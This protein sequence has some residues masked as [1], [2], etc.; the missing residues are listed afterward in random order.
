MK[1]KEKVPS[2]ELCKKLW[3]LGVTK[4]I[5]TE[6]SWVNG[7]LE[8]NPGDRYPT[9]VKLDEYQLIDDKAVSVFKE[10]SY[11]KSKNISIFPAP[12]LSETGQLLPPDFRSGKNNFDG[13]D[14][15]CAYLLDDDE[16]GV[17]GDSASPEQ[18][19]TLADTEPNA[20]AKMLI[21]LEENK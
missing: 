7:R 18:F 15:F 16:Y 2:L 5:K 12:D 20:R 1:T 14:K 9:P 17:S 6:R 4:D 19:M 3:E 8:L 10:S 13:N 11:T 21:A